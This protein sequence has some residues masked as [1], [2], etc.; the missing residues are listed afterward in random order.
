MFHI[1][2]IF[3]QKVAI[4]YIDFFSE[5]ARVCHQKSDG[6]RFSRLCVSASIDK[7]YLEFKFQAGAEQTSQFIAQTVPFDVNYHEE[8]FEKQ[9]VLF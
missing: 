8:I 7:D 9:I 1:Y 5:N 2:V 3:F 4:N 6:N